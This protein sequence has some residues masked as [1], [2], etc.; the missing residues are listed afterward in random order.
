MTHLKVHH[1]RPA[2]GAKTAKTRVGRGEA[3]QGQDRRPRHQGHQGPLPGA[4]RASRAG[5]CRCTC[6]CP[7]SRASRT[8]SGSSTRSSTWTSS[9]RCS[10]RAATVGVD[11]LVAKGAVRKNQPVKVLG[12]GDLAVALQVTRAR[13][14]GVGQGQD[15]RGRRLGH[16]ARLTRQAPSRRAGAR[17][18]H[19]R[20]PG[21]P[22]TSAVTPRRS[23][24][25]SPGP[26]G[27]TPAARVAVAVH[28]R[29][30]PD[31][32]RSRAHRFRSGL[33]Y[34]G[35]AQEAAVHA[36]D[37]AL[38]R[39]GSVVPAP[40]STTCNDPDLPRRR[41]R[42]TALYGLINLFSGGALLQ[43]SR[44]RARDHAVHHGSIIIQLL[45]V[46]IP[47]LETLKEE[48]QS[49]Q[50]KLT[51]YT[52]YL[53]VAL[54]ILQST[55]IVAL[56]RVP[57]ALF[58]SCTEE[59]IPRR[60]DLVILIVMVVTHDRRH[61]RHHVARRADHRPRHR[62][63]HVA[64]DLHLDHRVASRARAATI[65]HAATARSTFM[66]RARRRRS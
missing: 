37:H 48:G 41:S 22:A 5:R 47:R 60:V 43:L 8:R 65:L 61:R 57:A 28:G 3:Q 21:T 46:V 52:R 14:L 39:L 25:A 16:R 51:Q 18:R 45:I 58:Q 50:A 11:D 56:A 29:H 30:G 7:S 15:R 62:Q 36:G 59:L 33:P 19:R 54:A 23:V 32:R 64:A 1:L 13:V 44:L 38:F 27:P 53:T 34:A 31:A 66:R 2:P 35:P 6:G 9:P 49:G 12:N 40:A 17:R 10:R 63:R 42:T 20:T 26:R 24:P 55:G 4:G